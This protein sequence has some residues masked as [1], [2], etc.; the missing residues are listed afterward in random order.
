MAIEQQTFVSISRV[1][2][3]VEGELV[4]SDLILITDCFLD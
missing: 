3:L 2:E 1:V 4:I